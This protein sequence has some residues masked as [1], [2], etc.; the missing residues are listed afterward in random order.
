MEN[1][2]LARNGNNDAAFATKLPADGSQGM[3]SPQGFLAALKYELNAAWERAFES[4]FRC[5]C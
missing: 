1:H 5:G 3:N 4:S 2:E